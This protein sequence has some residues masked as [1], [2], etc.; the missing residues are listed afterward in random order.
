MAATRPRSSSSRRWPRLRELL[1]LPR[2]GG[3]AGGGAGGARPSSARR[4]EEARLIS[5]FVRRER[6]GAARRAGRAGMARPVVRHDRVGGPGGAD[7][8]RDPA[9]SPTSS[10]SIRS[11]VEDARSSIQFPKVEP[12]PGYLY[13]VLHGID[14]RK[15]KH[16]V[17]HPR[18]RLLHRAEL[19]G[20][21][22]RRR[23][24]VDCAPARACAI[25]TTGCWRRARSALFHRIVDTMVDHYRPAM[26]ALEQRI[27]HL[28][29]EA[30]TGH[31][32][33]GAADAQAAPRAGADAA[34]ADAAAR[35]D[36]PAGAAR[37]RRHLRRDGLPLSRRLRPRGAAGR[38]GASCF[39]IA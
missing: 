31:E 22:A 32:S 29:E 2:A 33:A 7:R 1:A 16:G 34:R 25:A 27:D 8:R 13:V 28:E 11:S 23:V 37:V 35:R 39:R 30:F 26:D 3:A 5:I 10:T 36:R 19:A 38:R 6:R 9:S 12:Y 14:V 24:H 4:R 20:H 21:R 18:R 15:G 17:R